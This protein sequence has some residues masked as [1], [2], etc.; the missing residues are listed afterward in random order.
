MKLHNY[1]WEPENL[2]DKASKSFFNPSGKPADTGLIAAGGFA[3]VFKAKDT[4]F[5][6]RYVALKIYKE[7]LQ[8]STSGNSKQSKYTLEKDFQLAENLSH[9][10][11]ISYKSLHYII[12]EDH[13]GRQ[14]RY[15]VIVMEFAAGG[16][17][18]DFLN[19]ST[20]DISTVDRILLDI[21]QGVGYLHENGITHRDLKPANILLGKNRHGKPLAK[22]TDFGIS[23]D[24]L[25]QKTTTGSTT[26]GVGTILYMAP[27]QHDKGKFGINGK[28][29]N[30]AD[31]WAIGVI[32]YWIF[33]GKVPFGAGLTDY[34]LIRDAILYQAP[35]LTPI[36]EKYRSLVKQCLQKY[37][38][39]RPASTE[40]LIALIDSSGSGNYKFHKGKTNPGNR[41]TEQRN[42]NRDNKH[43]QALGK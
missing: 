8:K 30:H 35:D 3:E 29:T 4:N 5:D 21:I 13:L 42:P 23:R 12:R 27:E 32:A 40:E 16:T 1:F 20:P 43:K 15:P 31:I 28:I 25:N 19:Q 11:I 2:W 18:S 10:N 22:I 26:E 37:A 24:S 36:P 17:L 6:N 33:T 34:G 39:D 7:G 38:R 14:S 9:P 41:K